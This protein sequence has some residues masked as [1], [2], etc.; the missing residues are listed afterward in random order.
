MPK[1]MFSF[2]SERRDLPQDAWSISTLAGTIFMATFTLPGQADMQ[3]SQLYICGSFCWLG[4]TPL[5]LIQCCPN[6]SLRAKE[7]GELAVGRA[8]NFVYHSGHI[9]CSR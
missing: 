1:E 8:I 7:E 6:Q 4:F 9:R 2:L 5:R 3:I